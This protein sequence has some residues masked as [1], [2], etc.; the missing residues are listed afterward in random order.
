MCKYSKKHA[1]KEAPAKNYFPHRHAE[2][3]LCAVRAKKYAKTGRQC[4]KKPLTFICI[5]E[6]RIYVRLL[7]KDG[8]AFFLYGSSVGKI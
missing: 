4:N 8:G 3:H 2:R 6:E 5:I 1:Y 7:S